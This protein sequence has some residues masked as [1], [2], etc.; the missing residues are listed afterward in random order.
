M[1]AYDDELCH[2]LEQP[3]VF[4]QLLFT[5]VLYPRESIETLDECR[6]AVEGERFS[7]FTNQF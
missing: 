5:A 3:W 4:S 6:D 2:D 1:C 7:R